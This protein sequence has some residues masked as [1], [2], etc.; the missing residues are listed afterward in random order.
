MR[1]AFVAVHQKVYPITLMCHILEVSRTGY[2]GWLKWQP[3]DRDLSNDQLDAHIR[4]IFTTHR[5][6]YGSPRITLEL[7]ALGLVC[8]E[9]RVAARMKVLE[10]RAKAKRKFKVTTDSNHT[11]PIAPNHLQQDFSAGAP[12][13]KWVSDV[14]YVWT[15]EGWLY[16]A[17]IMDLYSRAII[18][19]CMQAR[20]TRNLVCEALSSALERRYFPQQVIVHSDR[21]SQYASEDYRQLLHKH[22]LVG[23]MSKRGD[24]YDN[25]AMESFFHTL[26]VELVHDECY[27]TREQAQ[28]SIFE[29]IECYYNSKR[30]HS[31]IAYQTPKQFDARAIAA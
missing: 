10:L 16:L 2:Y 18:G 23:S 27:I 13:T 11:L 20:M 17:V 31:A 14:T 9:N 22:Q 30:R 21:G 26:K 29:Y 19:W 6:R 24:C 4:V 25:A 15:Q 3:S 28:Q 12:N 8:S 5:G 7:K 1:Y